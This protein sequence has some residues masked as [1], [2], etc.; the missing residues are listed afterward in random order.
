[1]CIPFKCP[2]GH[3]EHCPVPARAAQS[4]P[5]FLGLESSVRGNFWESTSGSTPI[6]NSVL[7]VTLLSSCISLATSG[8]AIPVSSPTSSRQLTKPQAF[9]PLTNYPLLIYTLWSSWL[10]RSNHCAILDLWEGHKPC[11]RYFSCR[12]GIIS[13]YFLHKCSKEISKDFRTH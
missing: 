3:C 12:T 7:P 11:F 9:P 8:A 6:C 13:I 10:H 2:H 5:A 4:L 1:M